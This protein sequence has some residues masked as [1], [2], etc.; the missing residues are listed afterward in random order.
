MKEFSFMKSSL[1]FHLSIPLEI[2]MFLE[3]ALGHVGMSVLP[4]F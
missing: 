1:T 2:T 3:G 4:T